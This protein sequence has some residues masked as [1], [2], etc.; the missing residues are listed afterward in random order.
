MGDFG[1]GPCPKEGLHQTGQKRS[2]RDQKPLDM[3][4]EG[5]RSFEKKFNWRP[6]APTLASRWVTATCDRTMRLALFGGTR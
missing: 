3:G 1:S 4:F 5:R 6:V 2:S